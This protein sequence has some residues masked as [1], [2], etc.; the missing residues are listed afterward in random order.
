MGD[1]SDGSS[2]AAQSAQPTKA[3]PSENRASEPKP[4]PFLDW[5]LRRRGRRANDVV[6]RPATELDRASAAGQRQMLVN[7][8]NMRDMR[9]EDV[10]IPRAD[11]VAVPVDMSRDELK[12]VFKES[13]YSRIPVFEETLDNPI[14]LIHL[15]DVALS[16]EFNAQDGGFSMQPFIR[17]LIFAPPS[18][19]IGALL[20]R[21]QS[22]R[23][24]MALVIDEF[25]GADGLVTMEDL[26]EQ[27]VGEI[28]DEHDSDEDQ[29]WTAES[30]GSYRALARSSLE[31]FEKA[32]AVDL[33]PD[34]LDEDVET[35]GGL[36]FML[37]GRV[38]ARGEVV[39]HPQGHEFEVLDADPRSIK[40]L[41]IRVKGANAR[42]RAAE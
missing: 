14:G 2:S 11:I 10:A 39:R 20:Q 21:M 1:N 5:V 41:R 25:G 16:D 6:E 35:L 34:D 19:P 33:L 28:A 32:A 8:R 18:M 38:P 31:E 27:I 12:S 13:G 42:E 4:V 36:V 3:I 37:A 7:L 15:K 22:A 29:M 30:D 9:I 40:R 24:H 23:M 17:P 26:V